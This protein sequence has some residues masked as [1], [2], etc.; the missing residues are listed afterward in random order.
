MIRIQYKDAIINGQLYCTLQVQREMN[1]G[2]YA[3]LFMSRWFGSAEVLPPGGRGELLA[4]AATTGSYRHELLLISPPLDR[5]ADKVLTDWR[6]R[7]Q[8]IEY[9]VCDVSVEQILA[10]ECQILAD[11]DERAI[12]DE[13]MIKN[14]PPS[15]FYE[16]HDGKHK[17]NL[18]GS[19]NDIEPNDF[20][21]VLVE[22]PAKII[23]FRRAFSKKHL[24]EL[25]SQA[26]DHGLLIYYSSFKIEGRHTVAEGPWVLLPASL[27]NLGKS[28]GPSVDV[29]DVVS[30]SV[31]V[32]N[33]DETSDDGEVSDENN[34]LETTSSDAPVVSVENVIT[35]DD[36]DS[37]VQNKDGKLICPYCQ[38]EFKK[39]FGLSNH[40][41]SIHP[42]RVDDYKSRK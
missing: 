6:A 40:V 5:N 20:V 32:V 18:S 21:Y 3:M 26:N 11:S 2:E 24:R 37:I 22:P 1:E 23:G 25:V 13:I 28:S 27:R 33:D 9:C 30:T 41:N 4:L 29:G 12:V 17:A 14:L 31:D 34:D 7:F 42:D 38:K 36:S 10:A 8:R 15:V 16:S 39:A 19:L 35:S